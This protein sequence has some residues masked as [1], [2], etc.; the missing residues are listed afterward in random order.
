MRTWLGV[1]LGF[2][3]G[4]GLEEG[5]GAVK[6]TPGGARVRVRNPG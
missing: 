6:T 1:G 4:L 5:A 3:F 2:G